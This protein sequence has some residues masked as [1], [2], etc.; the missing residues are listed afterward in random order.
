MPWKQPGRDSLPL[1]CPAEQ[2][3]PILD[4]P[5]QAAARSRALNLMKGLL[6][7]LEP[8]CQAVQGAPTQQAPA[9]HTL[10][11]VVVEG[12]DGHKTQAFQLRSTHLLAN[13][14][15]PASHPCLQLG[16]APGQPAV[17]LATGCRV[18]VSIFQ[19]TQLGTAL[20]TRPLGL[21]HAC[22]RCCNAAPPCPTLTY[23]PMATAKPCG[24]G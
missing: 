24:C 19:L 2:Q 8:S 21:C 11:P 12:P 3:G 16:M 18:A 15:G 17:C 1:S 14:S 10:V 4:F 22:W 13:G 7:L 23:W 6:Q 20:T 9:V 5:L